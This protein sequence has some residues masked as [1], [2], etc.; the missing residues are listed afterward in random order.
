MPARITR[1]SILSG[2]TRTMEFK[3][4]EQEE[5]ERLMIAY[6]D[7][8][9]ASLQEAFPLLSVKGIE[10]IKNGTLPNEWDENV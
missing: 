5:F 6:N 1:T 4:Y 10:F 7:G 3:Q 8:K 9:I 2:L